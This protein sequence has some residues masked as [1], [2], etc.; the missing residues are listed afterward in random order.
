[1]ALLR[2]KLLPVGVRGKLIVITASMVMALLGALLAPSARAQIQS[3]GE[4][5]LKAAFIYRIIGFVEWPG[6]PAAGAPLRVC[7]FGGNPFGTA[8]D[9]LRGRKVDDHPIEVRLSDANTTTDGL[10]DCHVLFVASAGEKHLARVVALAREAGVFT[11]GDTE[12]FARRGIMLNFY[13]ERDNVRFEINRDVARAGGIRLSSK[14]LS[15]AR[16]IDP[17]A[18]D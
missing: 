16:I 5:E 10:R 18:A 11:I 12:G 13:I 8:L 17:G 4:Y 14:L 2:E 15:L 1:M 9:M 6:K 3:S 7:V